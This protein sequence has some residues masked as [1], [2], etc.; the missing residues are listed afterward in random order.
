MIGGMFTETKDGVVRITTAYIEDAS[1]GEFKQYAVLR[2]HNEAETIEFEDI[3]ATLAAATT[4]TGIKIRIVL[5]STYYLPYVADKVTVVMTKSSNVQP[6]SI[7]AFRI[8]GV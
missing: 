5:N 8:L 3:Q 6:F 4:T 1:N 7:T 2:K